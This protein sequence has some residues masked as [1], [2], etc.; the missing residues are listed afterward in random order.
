MWFVA[1]G[2]LGAAV[3]WW[4]LGRAPAPQAAPPALAPTT[5]GSV[6]CSNG[7]DAIT[8]YRD[9]AECVAGDMA[10]GLKQ[11]IA[12]LHCYEAHLARAQR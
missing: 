8:C 3:M 6:W 11:V 10:A 2:A 1:G 5:T 9:E 4:W 7:D 12:E